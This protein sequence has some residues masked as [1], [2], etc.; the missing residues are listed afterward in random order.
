MKNVMDRRPA[1]G[2]SPRRVDRRKQVDGIIAVTDGNP[3]LVRDGDECGCVSV[4]GGGAQTG[5]EVPRTDPKRA[6]PIDVS[7]D[8]QSKS[9]NP[10]RRP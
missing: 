6:L 1:D 5:D 2:G 3:H 10:S 7:D 4:Q 8:C 9:A